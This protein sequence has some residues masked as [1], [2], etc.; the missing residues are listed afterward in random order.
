MIKYPFYIKVFDKDFDNKVVEK[1][2]LDDKNIF[3]YPKFIRDDIKYADVEMDDNTEWS[4]ILHIGDSLP[5]DSRWS[6]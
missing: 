3:F 5:K 2:F 6:V 1:Y 4:G